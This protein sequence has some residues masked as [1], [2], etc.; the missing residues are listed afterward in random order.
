MQED[1]KKVSPDNSGSQNR[2]IKFRAWDRNWEIMIY[3]YD[4]LIHWDWQLTIFDDWE[5]I[6]SKKDYWSFILMQY[7]WLKDKNLVE[8]YEGDVVKRDDESNWKYRRFAVVKINPDIQFDCKDIWPVNWIKN[9]SDNLFRYGNFAYK[10]THNH[11]EIIWNIYQ[12]TELLS[13]K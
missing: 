13:E 5:R 10:D 3:W 12:N 6:D 1:L 9:S 7:T 8:I 11:L 4:I 2:E